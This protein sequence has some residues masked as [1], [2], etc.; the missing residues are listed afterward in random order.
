METKKILILGAGSAIARAAA[1]AFAADGHSLYLAGRDSLELSKIASDIAIRHQTSVQYGVF[2][3]EAFALHPQ[4]LK[5]AIAAFGGLDGILL[6]FGDTGNHNLA[7]VDF[8][9]AHR[10][11]KC[12]FTGACSIL[13]H[14]SNYLAEQK[15]GFIIAISSVA[16]DRGRQS[17]YIYGASKG[18]LSLFL[19]GLR[20]RL[21]AYGVRVITIKPGFVDTAMTFGKPGLFLVASPKAV[22]EKIVATLNS[23]RDVV[24]IPGFW[25]YIMKITTKIP[26]SIFKK[27]KL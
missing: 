2:D 25:K 5:Q 16:G 1:N 27:M 22:G 23:K 6:A 4:F 19:Q 11:I 12:N 10:I 13:T 24:Y 17:N 3:A 9:E 20:N 8:E 18:A 26:E 7:L 15:K 21:F 14:C